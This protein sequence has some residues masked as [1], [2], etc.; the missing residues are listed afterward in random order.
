VGR[1]GYDQGRETAVAAIS[2]PRVTGDVTRTESLLPMFLPH[3]GNDTH[4][5]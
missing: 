4:S 3:P 5:R 1:A 2:V